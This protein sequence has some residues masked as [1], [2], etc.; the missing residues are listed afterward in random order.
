VTPSIHWR[1]YI[2][3]ADGD[4][5]RGRA[6]RRPYYASEELRLVSDD[7][8]CNPKTLEAVLKVRDDHIKYAHGKHLRVSADWEIE[9]FGVGLF[10][11]PRVAMFSY[12]QCTLYDART[13]TGRT[14]SVKCVWYDLH[15]SHRNRSRKAVLADY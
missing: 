2:N 15:L 10:D 4:A 11:G 14:L 5:E 7:D 13:V 12:N 8:L 3:T 6:P 1:K 9:I